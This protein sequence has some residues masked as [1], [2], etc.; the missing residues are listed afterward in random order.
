MKYLNFSVAVFTAIILLAGCKGSRDL[1][2][3][4][5]FEERLLDEITVEAIPAEEEETVT[6]YELAEYNPSYTRTNDLIHTKLDLKFDWSKQHVLGKAWLDFKPL[7]Y[8]TDELSLDA[9]GFD[10][11]KVQVA[12]KDAKYDYKDEILTIQLGRTYSSKE[13]Y[14][15]Y[16]E[17]TAKPNERKYGGS[18]AITSEKGLFF[19]NPEGKEADKP[20][21]IWTQGETE[22]NSA[23]FPTIDKPNERTT[24]EITLTLED[25]YKTLSNGLL[26]SSKKNADGTR[27]DYWVMDMPHAPYLFALAIGEFAIVKDKWGD[28]LLEYYVEPEYEKDAKAIFSNTPEMLTFFSDFIGVEYPWQKYSQVVVRDYVSGAMENTTAVIFGEFVQRHERELIDNHNERIVAHE[29]M[30][31]WFGDLV[32]CESWANLT[33]NEG[34]AN[35]SEYLWFEH[36]YGRDAADYHLLNEQQGYFGSAMQQGMHPL[37]HFGYEDKEEMFDAHSY[38]KGGAILHMLRHTVGTDAFREAL[39]VYLE[40]NKFTAVEAHDLRKAFEDVTGRDLNWFF[41][42]WFFSQGHPSLDIQYG[43]DETTGEAIVAIEQVQDAE[44]HLPIY[45]LPMAVDIYT[46]AGKA[47]VRKMIEM[48]ERQ[49]EFRFKVAQKPSLM[50]ADAEHALLAGINEEKTE[51]EYIFQYENAKLFK[52]RFNAVLNLRSAKTDAGKA[53]MKKALK[54]PF[55]AIRNTALAGVEKTPET[56]SVIAEMA[57]NDPRSQVKSSAILALAETND[58]QYVGI[59]KNAIEK[60]RAYNVMAAGLEALTRLD[61]AAASEYAAKLENEEN[62]SIISSVGKIYA[63]NGES[64]KME[65]FEKKYKKTDGYGAIDFLESYGKLAIGGGTNTMLESSEF[66]G[67]ISTDMSTSPWYRFGATKTI[68]DLYMA[69]RAKGDNANAIKMKGLIDDIKS[70][71]TMGQLKSLY[72]N[73]GL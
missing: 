61:K 57:K 51:E 25:K 71:E 11:H 44:D 6:S 22:N 32:T 58:A 8:D 33:M 54:D 64:G 60:E 41:N 28:L 36:K 5:P 38:N 34:F 27:T 9:K 65:F 46:G 14:Q 43:Y 12:G 70:K 4:E 42:Q 7:F 72:N 39:Q 18:E 21:Q 66:L 19:I 15:V 20:S 62:G 16:I 69:F 48:R 40:R 10:L 73:F 49:Q 24:Q 3:A 55:W 31:H 17:Y 59:A 53:I 30:H 56:L 45:I 26:K 23:W 1:I 67:G 68:N 50:I 52:A 13:K 35:Y 63:E 29:L 47:P 37:I 2:E